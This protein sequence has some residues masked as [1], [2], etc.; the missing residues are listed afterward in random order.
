MIKITICL[1]LILLSNCTKKND[2]I[3]PVSELAPLKADSKE[4]EILKEQA[5]I[6]RFAASIEREILKTIRS[7]FNISMTQFEVLS[8][9]YDQK[10]GTKKNF[11]NI[12]CKLY[13]TVTLGQQTEI[14]KQCQKPELRLALLDFSQNNQITITFD[15][16]EWSSVVGA[17]VAL[18]A[19]KR[20]CILNYENKKL[21]RLS[22]ENSVLQMAE[23]N[24][25]EELRMAEF[26][27]DQNAADQ[28]HVVGGFFKNLVEHRKLKLNIPFDGKIKIIEKELKVRDDFAIQTELQKPKLDE[29]FNGQKE[30]SKKNDS[31]SDSKSEK[32]IENNIENKDKAESKIDGEDPVKAENQTENNDDKEKTN[33]SNE[34]IEN[35][36]DRTRPTN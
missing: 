34:S 21:K 24:D 29:E 32:E 9:I 11:S 17:T 33:N 22:C 10:I 30:N 13:K 20:K 27:F 26:V 6:L 4:L 28:V 16:S 15:T 36:N 5:Q 1:L 14:I 35:N 18:T 25:V 19:P 2:V 31:K 12:D 7:D 23:Q 3:K 8:V